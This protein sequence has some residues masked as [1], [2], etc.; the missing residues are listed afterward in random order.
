M[1]NGHPRPSVSI[2]PPDISV[3]LTDEPGPIDPPAPTSLLQVH[4]KRSK[5]LIDDERPSSP[6]GHPERNRLSLLIPDGVRTP[7]QNGRRASERRASKVERRAQSPTPANHAG[8][9]H[10]IPDITVRRFREPKIKDN[11]CPIDVFVIYMCGN[12]KKDEDWNISVFLEKKD[13]KEKTV[14]GEPQARVKDASG[15]LTVPKEETSK[16]HTKRP[17]IKRSRSQTSGVMCWLEDPDMLPKALPTARIT[18]FGL[19][20]NKCIANNAP[21]HLK[22]AATNIL[23]QL[24]EARSQQRK[25]PI[26]FIGHG[27][28]NVVIEQILFGDLLETVDKNSRTHIV[29][30]TAAV[31]MFA[32]PLENFDDL[33]NWTASTF[34]IS[35]KSTRVF[36][37]RKDNNHIP[38][39]IWQ[40]F[41]HGVEKH[42]IPSLGYIDKTQE[43]KDTKL[44]E[45]APYRLDRT[46]MSELEVDDVARFSGPQ[47]NRF[48]NI[49]KAI[50]ESLVLH[51]LLSAAE[52]RDE[53]SMGDLIKASDDLNFEN[54]KSQTILHIA[55]ERGHTRLMQHLVNSGK[56]DL[57]RQDESGNTTLHI[58]VDPRYPNDPVMVH[59]LLKAGAKLGVKNK[60][61]KSAQDIAL[62]DTSVFPGIKDLIE[63][64][65]LV[66]GPSGPRRLVRGNP[67]NEKARSACHLTGMSVREIF[68]AEGDKPDTHLPVYK[69][70]HDLIY[71]NDK[72][73]DWFRSARD[74]K[75]AKALCQWY[76]IPMNNMAWVHDLFAKLEL[77]H[78]PWPKPHKRS[79]IFHGRY[80]NPEATRLPGLQRASGT[81]S[82]DN[83]VL[84]MPYVSYESSIRQRSL[85]EIADRI[86]PSPTKMFLLP[87]LPFNRPRL[88]PPRRS[89]N[90]IRTHLIPD[91]DHEALAIRGYLNDQNHNENQHLTLHPRRTLDQSYYYMLKDTSYRDRTQVVSRW[92]KSEWPDQQDHNLLMVD[93]LW[94]WFV[95]GKD[96]Q[97]DTIITSF[98]SRKGA[99]FPQSSR[100][101]DDIESTVLNDDNR[102][103]IEDSTDLV[104]RILSVCCNSF[105]RHQHLDPINFLQ[106]FESAI[107]RAEEEETRLFRRFRRRAKMLHALHEM[108][109]TYSKHRSMLLKKLLDILK[110]SKLLKEIKDILDEI[111]MIKAVIND[112][113]KVVKTLQKIVADRR[114][115][116]RGS[117]G[118]SYVFEV[119]KFSEVV[120][121]LE[122]TKESF[123]LMESH[124]KEVEKGLEHLLDLKQKQA[125][126][127][128]AR[129]SREGAEHAARQGST[130]LVFTVVTIIFLP[131]SFMASF[132]ALGISIFPKTEGE[133]NFPLGW[134]SALLF[135][136]SFAFSIPFVILAFNIEKFSVTWTRLKHTTNKLTAFLFLKPLRESRRIRSKRIRETGSK[137]YKEWVSWIAKHDLPFKPDEE[138]DKRLKAEMEGEKM[139]ADPPNPEWVYYSDSSSGGEEETDD[140]EYALVMRQRRRQSDLLTWMKG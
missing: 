11:R 75:S 32:P 9:Q 43:S 92:A 89:T 57:D 77:P 23:A 27:Y 108:H 12:Q 117:I 80:M 130:I 28:G 24:L 62:H 86:G 119:D 118:S 88:K 113:T 25:D 76:H 10:M 112:Q 134:V 104:S 2:L 96:G 53:S 129:S 13:K 140:E 71:T 137:W 107:G 100:E 37:A 22:H 21:I 52:T 67:A 1:D 8:F 109:R 135:G 111:K 93:Q 136:I 128:E 16:G 5:S 3:S 85:A 114:S 81:N 34:D 68:P 36:E 6:K 20:I 14:V 30:A 46:W 41:F 74:K 42:N 70:V 4:R 131:L 91:Q 138:M 44:A 120:N 48:R 39:V 133:N 122:E 64:P 17:S 83:W 50:S 90:D 124:A 40:R 125:N 126:L 7:T 87:N 101:A 59:C 72:I 63:R 33:V 127:W 15:L 94:L 66:E 38:K 47:D 123:D 78:W 99:I 58:A 105:D 56:V 110:E 45:H 132:F 49:S 65:P 115:I 29:E 54:R 31:T 103:S 79:K 95:K 139:A 106:F 61:G 98:P 35:R 51:Q 73:N 19:D 18:G 116:T 97:P 82:N 69:T 102:L 84:F 60:R 55:A 121:L 26:V